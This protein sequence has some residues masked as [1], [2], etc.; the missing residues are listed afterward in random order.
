MTSTLAVKSELEQSIE[1]QAR[2]YCDRRN[3]SD[4]E[5]LQRARAYIAHRSLLS[6]V[7]PFIDAK[8]RFFSMF[9][10]PRIFEDGNLTSIL[11]D[12]EKKYLA[13]IDEQI[14]SITQRYDFMMPKAIN[15]SGDW[16][17]ES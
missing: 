16:L 15:P 7:R 11:T 8:T 13:L 12:D 9:A 6:D 3:L 5:D 14:E 10:G 17:G 1:M 2:V 4:M